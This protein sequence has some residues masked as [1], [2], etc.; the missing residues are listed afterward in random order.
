MPVWA[1]SLNNIP[2]EDY[3][4]GTH[5]YDQVANPFFGQS[6]TFNSQPTVQLS[7]LLGL[8]PQY[9]AVTP[10]QATW[11]RSL[12]NFLNL[13]IQSRSYHGLTL[14]ASYSIRK[15]LTNTWGKD[16]QH[17]GPFFCCSLQ[18]P[19]NLM[20]AYGVAGYEMPQTLLLNYS[21]ELPFGRGRQ[22]M[23]N[24]TSFGYKV[25][26]QVIG[27]WNLA[28]VT[29]WNPKG[30]PVLV[31]QVPGGQTAPGVALRE[32]LA[33]GVKVVQSTNY[34][35]ALV[36]ASGNFIN[37]NPTLVLNANAFVR[38]PDF[39]IGNSPLIFPNVRNPGS[40]F[41]DATLLKKFPLSAEGS[42]YFEIRLEAQNIFN[43]A[44]FNQI[45]NNMNDATFGGIL[46]KTGQRIMQVGAR[47]FF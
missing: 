25:L 3:S 13:Q 47:F 7:Q 8:S 40:F 45:D 43:H 18:N 28:G 46:G 20:E 31:P 1:W 6:Q 15:T 19:H 16:I 29:T 22:F 33:P 23:S 42:R 27:G 32:S 24:G 4:L 9:S 10:G 39:G 35:S 11:G 26:N 36:D 17:T 41:T 2:V 34:S 12:A 30:T 21:Y 44:N 37:Q 14:L 5:L 38:T